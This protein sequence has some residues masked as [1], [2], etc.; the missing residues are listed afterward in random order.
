MKPNAAASPG[1][2]SAPDIEQVAGHIGQRVVAR[3]QR[4]VGDGVFLRVQGV[5]FLDRLGEHPHAVGRL[6]QRQ[7][8]RKRHLLVERHDGKRDPVAP[9]DLDAPA[10]GALL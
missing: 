6:A 8:A 5:N 3:L 1:S 4:P 10:V 2:N 9:T 7:P